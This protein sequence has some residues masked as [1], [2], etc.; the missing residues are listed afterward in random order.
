MYTY[1]L[2][3]F[4]NSKV[5]VLL[6]VLGLLIGFV[7]LLLLLF[8]EMSSIKNARHRVWNSVLIDHLYA[9]ENILITFLI[10]ITSRLDAVVICIMYCNQWESDD[11]QSL[12]NCHE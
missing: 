5:L 9:S 10:T 6:G 3:L 12:S 2:A 4:S 1:T 7:L 8:L 11:R